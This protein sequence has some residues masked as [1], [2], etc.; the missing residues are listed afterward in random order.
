MTERV[1]ILGGTFDPVHKAHLE[2]A[3]AALEAFNLDEVL[4]VPTGLPVHKLGRTHAS[5]SDRLA[6]LKAALEGSPGF[7]LSTLEIERDAA[8]YTIDT[9][10]DVKQIYGQES[11]LFLILGED[12]A[13]DL[14]NWKDS[15]EIAR[16]VTV[17]Y[18]RRPGAAA[19]SELPSGFVFFELDMP[20]LDISSTAIREMLANDEDVTAE[21]PADTLAYIRENQLYGCIERD[22]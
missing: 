14:G 3:R 20:S 11:E 12:A 10:R 2:L 4:F 6:M 19:V 22:L 15:R 21:L 18:A 7:V 16:L 9:L 13:R 1:G 17:L 8:S 5:I